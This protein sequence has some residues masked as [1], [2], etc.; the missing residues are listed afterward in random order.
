MPLITEKHEVYRNS[1]VQATVRIRMSRSKR[2]SPLV[3]ALNFQGKCGG[4]E[5]LSVTPK[6][7]F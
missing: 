6:D 7:L 5:R 1:A 4:K 2:C 3:A